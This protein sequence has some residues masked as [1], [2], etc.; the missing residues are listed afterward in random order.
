MLLPTNAV[1]DTSQLRG[2]VR[3]RNVLTAALQR[4][5]ALDSAAEAVRIAGNALEEANAAAPDRSSDDDI[6]SFIRSPY[7]GDLSMTM[8]IFWRRPRSIKDR[9]FH[10]FVEWVTGASSPVRHFVALKKD[11]R[12]DEVLAVVIDLGLD[13]PSI[14]QER[15][16]A[17]AKML[18][19]WGF[20][21]QDEAEV[22]KALK[23][24]GTE[25]IV[26][27]PPM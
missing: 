20:T 25:A 24:S 6:L 17:T 19:E 8:T 23:M 26:I 3:E 14:Y 10:E 16:E 9:S 1:V 21:D 13:V 2:L 11:R 15:V 4:I 7:L 22:L 18:V 5:A 27:E 12:R